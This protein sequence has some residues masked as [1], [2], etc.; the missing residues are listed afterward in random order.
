MIHLVPLWMQCLRCS[1]QV[2]PLVSDLTEKAPISSLSAPNQH[3]SERPP[4]LSLPDFLTSESRSNAFFSHSLLQFSPPSIYLTLIHDVIQNYYRLPHMGLSFTFPLSPPF[5]LQKRL[6]V[7]WCN[8]HPWF[9]RPGGEQ[10]I[11]IFKKQV[12]SRQAS[13]EDVDN[14]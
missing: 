12:L 13:L 6:Y 10:R 8:I 4:S 7:L 14:Q 2:S 3:S 5:N 9:S 11:C 1:L